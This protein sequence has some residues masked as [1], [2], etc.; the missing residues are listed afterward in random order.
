[1]AI[2]FPVGALNLYKY[3]INAFYSK[4]DRGFI[5]DVPD[6]KYCSALGGTQEEAVR[7]VCK[8][9]TSGLRRRRRMGSGCRGRG[10]G[11]RFMRRREGRAKN[12]LG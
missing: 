11:R 1:M 6:L 8:V 3:H 7:E 4:D 5:A 10:I 2:Q 12:A 9:S